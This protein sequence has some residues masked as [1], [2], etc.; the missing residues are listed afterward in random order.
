MGKVLYV[1]MTAKRFKE[2]PLHK[3]YADLF[4]GGRGFGIAY[5]FEHFNG[6]KQDYEN[7]FKQIDP[8]SKDNAIVLCS[9]VTTGTR[10]PTSGRLH[11]NFKSP[12]TDA[13]GSTSG[14]GYF[15]VNLK[16]T[17]YDVLIISG[18]SKTPCILFISNGRVD[19]KDAEELNPLDSATLREK[20]R[21]EYSSKAQVLTIGEGGRKH[22]RFASVMTDSGKALG[23]GGGGAV[24]GSKNLY[25]VAVL[26]EPELSV[27]VCHPERL[28][29]K[30][31]DS[32][33][34]KTKL[35]LNVGKFT[36]R[37]EFFGILPSFGSLGVLGMIH[38][39]GQLIHNNMRDTN[40]RIEDINRISGEALRHHE[41]DAGTKENKIRVKKGG[42][43]N[44]PILCKRKI[45]IVDSQGHVIA[46]GEGP[47]FESVA[48]LGANLSI[49]HL[50]TI[51][52]ANF[53][54]N[55]YGI[56]TITLGSTIA[57]LF[58]LYDV[59]AKKKGDLSS[60]EKELLEDIIEL[61][62]AVGKPCFGNKNILIPLIHLIG[63]Q[64]GIGKILAQGSY[65]FCKHYG[66]PELSMS[67]KKLEL[68][69]YDPRGSFSQALCYEMNNRGGCHLQGGYT[70]PQSHCA[71]YGEWPSDRIEGTPLISRNAT[72]KNTSIDI[73]GL[74]AYS[75]FSLGLDEYATL[76]SSVT[77]E[78]CNSGILEVIS[79]RTV[80]L[81]RQFNHLCGLTKEDDILPGR[82]YDE[83]IATGGKKIIL[84][85]QDF[86][87]M[88][89]LYY[90]S[91]GWDEDGIPTAETLKELSVL[92]I[93]YPD[94]EHST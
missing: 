82:F 38:H 27:G 48:L 20:I 49:Y 77:G 70:A 46:N 85:R 1:D 51:V 43:Y 34:Q 78:E 56:D 25:A 37:E 64:E 22:C 5:L 76:V 62:E 81:E 12:L 45:Q 69:A 83:S 10:V 29:L 80:T 4:M 61:S 26:P 94:T 35:K 87:S 3:D 28:K 50:E 11:M 86:A 2:K 44:C 33:A 52:Q 21:K 24:F 23:R 72:L 89:K 40:H 67:V 59:I 71:G 9:S 60:E 16:R 30:T 84:D 41:R 31:K 53:L 13:L 79:E 65:R 47:E 74:C 7:P 63:K 93:V 55:T 8:L 19:F 17:G 36:K 18:S 15:S 42:C 68:P 91:F 32:V 73:M 57:S 75:G 66:H 6:L 39:F 14:G 58:D 92:K 88:R 54:A 90:R